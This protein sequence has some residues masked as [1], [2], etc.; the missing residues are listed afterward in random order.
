MTDDSACTACH[1]ASGGKE[2]ILDTHM[3]VVPP[4]PT[5]TWLGGTNANTNAAYLPAAG[6]VPSGA[7]IIN[8]RRQE[9]RP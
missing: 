6:F 2:G 1:P 8:L 4:D 3:P 7:S 5:A 9:R